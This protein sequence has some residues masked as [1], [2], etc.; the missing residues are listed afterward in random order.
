MCTKMSNTSPEHHHQPSAPQMEDG[1]SAPSPE[2]QVP[3]GTTECVICM[4]K[5]VTHI[6]NAL[7]MSRTKTYIVSVHNGIC[8]MWTL[9]LLL[10]V[11]KYPQRLSTV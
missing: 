2:E 5:Q 6:T 8:P 9:V 10:R 3:D 4:D 1:A 7:S 11:L